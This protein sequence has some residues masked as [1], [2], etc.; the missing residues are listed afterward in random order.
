MEN[1]NETNSTDKRCASR[2]QPFLIP[3]SIIIAGAIIALAVL[4][5]GYRNREKL[6]ISE[7]QKE[8]SN[9]PGPIVFRPISE[10]DHVLGNR[11]SKIKIIE[12]SDLECPFCKR[13]HSTVLEIIKEYKGEVSV[14]YR[15][16]PLDRIHS[17]ARKEAEA[18]ECAN[19][20]G[21]N[22][23]FW[24]Y[25][26]KVFEITPS[27]DGL[28]PKELPRI[29]TLAGLDATKF[30]NCLSSEKYASYIESD[31]QDALSAQGE[32]TPYSLVIGKDGKIFDVISG[33]LPLPEV[34]KII[35]Q[36]L[37]K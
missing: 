11:N 4:F 33:A 13:F 6:E 21:G 8:I 20:L 19:E 1:I 12:Y 36:A 2:L 37:E 31:F 35:D 30:S 32:G 26:T 7:T 28:D 5:I 14:I 10:T 25:I 15:H 17:K 9:A 16:F 27:N 29:A 22:N 18:S 24:A 3:I 34:K 23:A